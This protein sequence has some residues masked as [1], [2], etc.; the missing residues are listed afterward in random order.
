MGRKHRKK[1]KRQDRSAITEKDE[2]FSRVFELYMKH[3]KRL[4]IIPILLLLLCTSFLTLKYVRTGEIIDRGVSLKGGITLTV[5]DTKDLGIKDTLEKE[6][7]ETDI[8]MNIIKGST[9]TGLIISADIT[10][11]SDISRF[12]DVIEKELG[13]KDYNIEIM[14]ASLGESF[15]YQT[16][17]AIAIAFLFMS[18]VVFWYFKAFIPSIAVV[19]SAFSDML[20]TV[21]VTSLLGM[22]LSTAGIAAFLMLIGYSVDTDILL[23]TKVLNRKEWSLKKRVKK[24]LDTGL[25]MSMTTIGAVLAGLFFA[26][27]EVLRQIMTILLIG[28]LSDLIYTWLLNEP[29]LYIYTRRKHVKDN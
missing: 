18:I 4:L 6:F 25:L 1:T 10:E 20:T 23:S 26:S 16:I 2:T 28:L 13:T 3:N 15:F 21:A 5:A 7:P 9:R 29:I 27:S 22:K 12:R 19:L 17:I 14:G 8:V 11:D 24:A